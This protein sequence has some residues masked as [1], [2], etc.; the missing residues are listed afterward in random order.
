MTLVHLCRY[1]SFNSSGRVSPRFRVWR[2][3]T[4]LPEVR[5]HADVGWEGSWVV[6]QTVPTKLGG[7]NC[8]NVLVCWSIQSFHWDQGEETAPPTP[9]FT[10]GSTQS[11]VHR[12]WHP[13]TQTDAGSLRVRPLRA[14]RGLALT[15]VVTGRGAAARPR[16]HIPRSSPHS[17]LELIGIRSV[18]F[19]TYLG[20]A[21][22]LSLPHSGDTSCSGLRGSKC[23]HSW[24]LITA[25]CWSSP[26]SWGP[27]SLISAPVAMEVIATPDWD[28]LDGTRCCLIDDRG[29]TRSS[30]Q[31]IFIISLICWERAG[32]DF[33]FFVLKKSFRWINGSNQ[34]NCSD[35]RKFP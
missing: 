15:S 26:S 27:R 11:D 23:H 35:K 2:S 14:S 22:L 6:L 34:E 13:Q 28:Y 29:P 20:V 1:N 4:I 24:H 16:R 18:M 30:E 17:V 7:W 12:C 10:L 9:N 21:Q 5:S 25:P 32:R 31:Q 19:L 8:P 33:S 3:L